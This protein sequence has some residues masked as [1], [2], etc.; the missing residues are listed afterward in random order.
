LCKND[1]TVKALL[2]MM[3]WRRL[4]PLD[5]APLIEY[6][7]SNSELLSEIAIDK[8]GYTKDKRIHDLAIHLLEEKGLD[9]HALGLL[10]KNYRKTDDDIIRKLIVKVSSVPQYVQGDIAD[11]YK[12]HRSA[13]ALP[14][15]LHVYQNGYCTHCRHGIVQAMNH[16]KVLSDGII[17]ECL[18]DSYEDTRKKSNMTVAYP[19]SSLTFTLAAG[20]TTIIAPTFANYLGIGFAGY[21]LEQHEQHDH[22][23]L[24]KLDT[25]PNHLA[26][27]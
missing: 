5:I 21:Q 11:I 18:H 27:Q 15:L 8:L 10:K 4:F 20:S 12:H 26:N 2:L 14:I 25:N 9:S 7:N 19:P 23:H 6:A 17:E 13:N 1:E 3:F 24:C 22:R 16:C